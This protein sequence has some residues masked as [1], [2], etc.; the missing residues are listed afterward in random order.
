MELKIKI[1]NR[2]NEAKAF[3][4]YLKKLPFIEI[5]NDKPTPKQNTLINR[6]KKVKQ[7]ADAGL[8]ETKTLKSFLS[9]L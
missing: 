7:K 2:K 4:E 6:L 3:L 9:D 8:Y 1:D 5:K